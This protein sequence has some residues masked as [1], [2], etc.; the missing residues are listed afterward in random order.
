MSMRSLSPLIRSSCSR[1]SLLPPPPL[2]GL[3]VAARRRQADILAEVEVEHHKHQT[4]LVQV[5]GAQ[6]LM[7]H[8]LQHPPHLMQ[9]HQDILYATCTVSRGRLY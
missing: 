9:D 4:M 1:A 7:Q 2:L 3:P 5:R 6:H 8:L